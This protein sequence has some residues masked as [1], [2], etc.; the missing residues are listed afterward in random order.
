MDI[1]GQGVMIMGSSGIGKSETALELVNKGYHLIADDVT[2]F[3]L[4][5]NEDLVGRSSE[6][7]KNL[8]EVGAWGS[9]TS[10]ISSAPRP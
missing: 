1:M 9:S 6:P 2:E 8:M 4:D 10:T 3:Y 5:S 7:I